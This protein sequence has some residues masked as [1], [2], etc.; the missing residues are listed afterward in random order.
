[1]KTRDRIL[2]TSLQLFNEHGEPRITTN[3]IADELDISPGN[4]Y[5]HFRNKDDIIWLLFQQFERQMDAALQVPERRVPN[6]EDMWLYLHLAFENIWEYRFFYRDLD[7]ILSRNKKLR[8]HFRRIIERKVNTATA[9]C[10][11]LAEAGI[12]NATHDDIAA[13]ARNIAVIAT[14]WL[15]FQSIRA[16]AANPRND[17]DHLALG[18]YQVLS[19]VAPFLKGEARE[20]LQQIS[21]EYLK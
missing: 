3:H 2:Q 13:L 4:L 19:L 5:Y 1:M 8:T 20:L 15:N 6:M 12:M 21:R 17:S 11:G 16:S 9:I 7:N 14:Y 10:T 18:V